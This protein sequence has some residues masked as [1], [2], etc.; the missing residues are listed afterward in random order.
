MSCAELLEAM[1]NDLGRQLSELRVDGGACVNDLLMQL[2]ADLLNTVVV[3]PKTIETT[4]L[5]AAILA[6]IGAGL[7]QS[8]AHARDTWQ[9][10]RR[11]QPNPGPG[12]AELRQRWAAAVSRA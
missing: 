11:F 10:E 7:F 3:R 1:E 2:Q 8:V 9:E 6:G 4:A 5:G 12:I